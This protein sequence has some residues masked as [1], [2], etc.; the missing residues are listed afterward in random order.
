MTVLTHLNIVSWE[1]FYMSDLKGNNPVEL[2]VLVN[3]FGCFTDVRE[4]DQL[5]GQTLNVKSI[6]TVK[7]I[8]IKPYDSFIFI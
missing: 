6:K 8:G 2:D 3:E 5:Y 4:K 1:E 7:Q